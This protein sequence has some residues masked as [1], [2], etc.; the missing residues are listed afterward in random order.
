MERTSESGFP[1]DPVYD[2]S[3]LTDFQPEAKLARPGEYPFTRGVYPRVDVDRPWTMRQYAGFVTARQSSRRYHELIEAG[4]TGLPVASGL[5]APMGH[6]E[7][8]GAAAATERI[9]RSRD[10]E[11]RQPGRQGN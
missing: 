9:L 11:R 4:T 7:M 10:R 6:E 1:V 5:P 2:A 3:K 8:G